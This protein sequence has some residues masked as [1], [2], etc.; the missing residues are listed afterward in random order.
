M[1]K[2]VYIAILVVL[3]SII[4]VCLFILPLTSS[5]YMQEIPHTLSLKIEEPTYT[6]VFNANGGT[7]TMNPQTFKYSESK[8]L[9]ENA[10][11]RS[12]YSFEKWTT[13]AN[14][15][16][17][18]YTDKQVVTKLSE[19]NGEQINL[20]AQWIKAVAKVGNECFGSLQEAINSVTTSD[21]TVVELLANV[22]ENLTVSATQ[23]ITFNLHNHT[24]TNDT[25]SSVFKNFGTIRMN[26]GTIIQTS[27]NESAFD[28]SSSGKF[29]M[30][31]GTIQM[32]NKNGKQGIYNNGGFVE[33]SGTA[34]ITA[35]GNQS[36][37]NQQRPAVHNLSNGTLVIT[38][39]T[40]VSEHLIAVKNDSGT[41]TIGVKDGTS[42]N[43]S[44]VIQGGTYGV[45]STPGYSFYDGIIKGKI[46]AV[47]N[48]ALITDKE[49]LPI[50][51]LVENI[52]GAD[53][54]AIILAEE[55]K[56][57]TL[58]PAGGTVSSTS[59][60]VRAGQPVGTLP[61]PIKEGYQFDGWF[62]EATGGTQVTENTIITDDITFYAH[63]TLA[64]FFEV[65]GLGYSTLQ[66][67]INA[68]PTDG[69][70]TRITMTRDYHST[71]ATTV[72]PGKNVVLDFGSH[73]ITQTGTASNPVFENKGTIS[74]VSGTI[75]SNANAAA[76]NNNDNA[77]FTMSGGSIIA[78]GERQAI[79]NYGNVVIS[80]GYLSSK[81]SGRKEEAQLPRGTIQNLS[82]ANSTGSVTITGGTIVGEVQQAISNQGDLIIGTQDGSINTSSPVIQGQTIGI[83]T[84]TTFNF[85]DGLIKGKTDTISGTV[86]N[87][88]A[89]SQI[90]TGTDGDYKTAHLEISQNP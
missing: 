49:D 76:I 6:I 28:N 1:N 69:T 21:E 7:G 13:N 60:G 53:Y 42:N 12:G 54:N 64:A 3:I 16:G 51:H 72:A 40:I 41:V 29:Y 50:V 46:N 17:T 57:V 8:A 45:S 62:T 27:Q 5:K 36:N 66:A 56:T 81:A 84:E 32:T 71:Q 14:G 70:P 67:A 89:G 58:N 23:N 15:S 19:V 22:K 68:V 86:T 34:T 90:V 59:I 79:Y 25:V 47:N 61:V 35:A 30:S 85:F 43:S 20:Y 55:F 75:T 38:G 24:I 74:M 78:T 9:T 88:E 37:Q 4:V 31:G 39:G 10:F 44:P 18:A 82:S 52:G 77:T 33:I 73:T 48:E 2:K 65:N 26:N 11:E 80:G 87:Q 63:W 83:E